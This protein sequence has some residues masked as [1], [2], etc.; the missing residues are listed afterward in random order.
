VA[1]FRKLSHQFDDS[2]VNPG[3]PRK[4]QLEI[5]E[6]AVVRKRF[7]EQQINCRFGVQLP[8]LTDWPADIVQAFQR[9]HKGGSNGPN[10]DTAKTGVEVFFGYLK[11]NV[12]HGLFLFDWGALNL[13]PF[14][15]V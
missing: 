3:A 5:L 6:L 4:I 14:E 8:Q 10:W 12:T 1:I 9:V 11:E 2:R 7:V 15:H 13:T